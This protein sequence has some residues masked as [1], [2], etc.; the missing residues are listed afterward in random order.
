MISAVRYD[1]QQFIGRM[2]P[3]LLIALSHAF[4]R[5]LT[6]LFRYRPLRIIL[7]FQTGE[8]GLEP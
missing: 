4:A 6:I 5:Y 7:M 3:G 1:I 8:Q 2:A